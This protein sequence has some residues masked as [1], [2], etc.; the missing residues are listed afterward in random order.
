MQTD[1]DEALRRNVQKINELL[2]NF[3]RSSLE[4]NV[5]QEKDYL[6][7]EPNEDSLN[8][9][10]CWDEMQCGKT[11]CP[12]YESQDYRCW[13]TVGTLCGETPQG[14]FALKHTSC[15]S[16]QAFRNFTNTQIGALYENIGILVRHFVDINKQVRDY[17]IRD[18]LTGL[19]NRNYL[20]L[21]KEREI[22]NAQREDTNIS[23][24][25][26]DL[27]DFKIVN[28]TYGHLVGDEILKSFSRFLLEYAR[29]A[30]LLFRFGGDEFLLLMN[31]AIKE[32]RKKAE[33]RF[34]E[35][36]KEWNGQNKGRLP[37][38]ISFSL[39]GATAF[40]TIK[41]K[42]L[43]EEADKKLYANKQHKKITN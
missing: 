4:L 17:A 27:N 18:N 2:E 24:I 7:I 40:G 35:S 30:D 42:N 23:I 29:R 19:Y 20:N 41:F 8:K 25:L 10:R 21:V 39:G 31:G 16:C 38:P 33:K 26:F 15:Y 1:K 37:V 9:V 22:Q 13:L 34:L 3:I 14:T 43:M 36:I 12:A 32:H 6:N 11:D 28:D 5:L